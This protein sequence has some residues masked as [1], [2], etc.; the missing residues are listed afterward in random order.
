MNNHLESILD[1]Y[2]VATLSNPTTYLIFKDNNITFTNQISRATKTAGRTTANA[3]KNEFYAYTGRTDIELV[4][5]PIKISYEIV[6]EE[7]KTGGEHIELL[8]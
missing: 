7:N 1:R 2:V 5:L 8:S 4:V 3:I 6:K